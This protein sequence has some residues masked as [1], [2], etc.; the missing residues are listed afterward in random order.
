[1]S[2]GINWINFIFQKQPPL[3]PLLK[4]RRGLLN[5][6]WFNPPPVSG[7]AGGGKVLA[8]LSGGIGR[9]LE[10][11]CLNFFVGDCPVGI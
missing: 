2:K 7:G 6:R 10:D 4:G 3:N 1:M 9:Y 8:A 5:P 11:T